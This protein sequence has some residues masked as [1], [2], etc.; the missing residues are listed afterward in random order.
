MPDSAVRFRL[1]G[2]VRVFGA[3]GPVD[4]TGA[5]AR[6]LLALLLMRGEGGASLDEIISAV[7][8]GPGGATRDSAYHYLSTL[9]RTLAAGG[10]GGELETRRPGYRLR[11]DPEAV[12]WHRFRRLAGAA[13]VA[14]DQGNPA[15]AAAL[16]R[17]ALG[18]WEGPPLADVGDRLEPLRRQMDDRR[19]AAL[20]M[21]AGIE[22]QQRR[23]PV[24]V[25]LLQDEVAAGPV[26]E[27]A[28]ALLI[29]ALTA[30]GRRDEAGA[31]Y[32]LAGERLR[33][34]QGL[35]PGAELAAAH[36]RALGAAPP[37]AGPAEPPI[38]GLPRPD[39]HFTD[40]EQE[41]RLVADAIG[42]PGG[43]SLCAIYGMGGAGKTALAVRAAHELQ[44]AFPDGVIFLDLHG[45]AEE[46]AALSPTQT[47]DRLVRRLRVDA[48]RIPSEPGELAAFYQDLL[49]G[50]RILLVLDNAR[51]AGQV[52]AALPRPG[53]CAAIVTSRRRLPALDDALVLPLDVL[54]EDD[55]AALFLAVAGA[56]DHLDAA[57]PVLLRV[58]ELCGRLPLAIRIAAARYRATADR[59]LAELAAG[60]TEECDRLSELE[61][62]DR[63]VAA[64]F[65]VSLHDLPDPVRRLFGL[66]AVHLDGSFDG[67][68]AAALADLP[69]GDARRHLR[70]LA[71]RHLIAESGPGRYRFHDLV[72]VFARQQDSD[73]DP[74]PLRRL[75]DY[76][77]RAADQADRRIT[78]H[79]YRV[80]LDLL[81]REWSLPQLD[82]YDDALA[83]L[84]AEQRNLARVCVA[85]GAAGLDDVCWQ[86]AYTLRGFYFLTK[87]WRPWTGTHEAALA[88]ARRRGDRRA[89]AMTATNLGLAH[90]E[91]G[92][93]AGAERHF[94]LAE[95][96]FAAEGDRHGLHTARISLAWL[97]YDEGDYE[98]FLGWM[99]PALDFYVDEG[100]ERNAAITRRGIG[101]AE[102]ALH[103]TV[104]A[105]ESLTRA[106]D[107]FDRLD[108]RMDAAM[109]YNAL[110][111]L[112]QGGGDPARAAA[113]FTK[114]IAAA[115][116]SGSR[117]EQAR[118]RQRLG[119]LAAAAG[120]RSAA[121]WYWT[122]AWA[123][124]DRLR[125]PQADELQAL[126]ASLD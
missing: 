47:L 94:T 106:L 84:T 37:A 46:H 113:A 55:A 103:R 110:G 23:Y 118:A 29:D 35:E 7:W 54:G 111:E 26:R 126:L 124:Y 12:D 42:G 96:L 83:W 121:R 33:D 62:D 64:S 99:R 69:V 15:A 52:R 109:T 4:V 73:L 45:Y 100:A 49:D 117:F 53:G 78:P 116:R 114:A 60:L 39:P 102:A 21:L 76:F 44:G 58:V 5:T 22:A 119:E 108:L 31:V 51:D 71:D 77:L 87:R 34:E 6:A 36:R 3:D 63:S 43:R 112:H 16:L 98:Q 28:A 81:G 66:L 2:P 25:E 95:Q 11:V 19:R 59:S 65:R 93:R 40:R 85:A 86:L 61:D 79:R 10:T 122:Q 72:A 105:A 18:L 120:D 14:R 32:R 38:S 89:E 125:A 57:D 30:L 80:P 74:E 24:V 67:H 48:E 107:T 90:Q 20:E 17:E 41:L 88:A 91:Q 115:A 1:L 75:A 13:R 82:G 9:R 92:D 123:G 68:A 56:G 104:A 70:Q 27:G 8:G 101:L 97:R 50:R